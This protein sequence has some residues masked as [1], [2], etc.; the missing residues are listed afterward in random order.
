M[1]QKLNNS[2]MYGKKTLLVYKLGEKKKKIITLL[3][4]SGFSTNIYYTFNEFLNINMMY[5]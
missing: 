4:V 2:N 3:V 5:I 1:N